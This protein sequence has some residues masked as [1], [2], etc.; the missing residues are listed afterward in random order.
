MSTSEITE[1]LATIRFEGSAEAFYNPAQEFNRDLTVSVLRIL[2]KELNEAVNQNNDEPSVKKRKIGPTGF[3]VLDALSASG[4]RAL[5]FSKEVEGVTEVWANDFSENAVE[6]IKKN[7]VLNGVDDLIHVSY[8]DATQLMSECRQVDKR[9]HAVDLDPYGSATPF[10][11]TAVQSVVDGGILMVTCTDMATLCGNTPEAALSKYGS[12]P[13][14]AKCCHE[15]AIRML[16]RSIQQHAASYDRY[17]EPLI[18]VSVDFY[19]RCFVRIKTG[20][21]N[22][23]EGA[24]KL[25]NVLHCTGC[26]SL[27]FQPLVKKVVNGTSIKFL[28]PKPN[29]SEIMDAEGNCVHCK[30]SVQLT[31]PFYTAP[32]FDRTFVQVLLKDILETEADKRLGTHNRLVGVLT[33]ML[34]ELD[35][36]PFYYEIDQLV[37]ICKARVPKSLTFRSV[38]LNAGYRVSGSHCNPKAIKTDAP[39]VVLWDTVRSL[40]AQEGRDMKNFSEEAPGRQILALKPVTPFNPQYHPKAKENSRVAGLLRFQDNHGKNHGPKCKAKGSVNTAKVAAFAPM[41]ETF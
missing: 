20:A 35:D 25:S 41:E 10:L 19:I 23:K 40:F 38:I 15:A 31:G 16:L 21:R 2:G 8:A 1:G 7:A 18:C 9:F 24:T 27:S 34:E 17:I 12:T 28:L 26:H 3:R 33:V 5:R 36:V 37:N 13:L 4:L 14:K 22:V 11:N 39:L 29:N 6:Y 30:H 32:Y